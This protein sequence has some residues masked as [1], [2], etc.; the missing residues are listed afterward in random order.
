MTQRDTKI[1]ATIGPASETPD[2]LGQ[3]IDA[4]LGVAR[5]NFSH[6]VHAAHGERF[7]TIRTLAKE[8]N[9]DVKIM[10]DLQG[11]KMRLGTLPEE[12][13]FVA[14]GDTIVLDTSAT[15]YTDGKIPFPSPIFAAGSAV[16][17]VIFI[18]DGKVSGEI[19]AVNGPLFSVRISAGGHLS[20]QKGVNAPGLRLRASI[21][22]DKDRND[23]EFCMSLGVD[24]IAASFVRT[25]DDILEIRRLIGDRPIKIIAKIERP[26]ALENIAGIL[27]AS[28]AIMV[29][30]GDLG[31]ETPLWELPIRQKELVAAAMAAGRPAIVATQMFESMRHDS[32]PT[33]AEVSDVANAVLDGASAVM[34][35][36]ETSKGKFPIHC[37]E[38]M[39]KII[40]ATEQSIY[41]RAKLAE[42]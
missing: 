33:R 37:I 32:V 25:K 21:L 6:D 13:I 12:G 20:S 26:E 34:L 27:E 42:L 7:R 30:R 29:A 36:A 8:K 14:A 16:G 9:K 1:V 24:F 17:N 3:M 11:P 41:S 2:V 23:L 19:I 28:D 15:A 22:E 38:M 31:V 4:G 39:A 10:G 40:A 5:L 35:S 18:D